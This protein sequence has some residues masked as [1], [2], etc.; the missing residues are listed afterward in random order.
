MKHV[1]LALLVAISL[2]A[3]EF[4]QSKPFAEWTDKDVQRILAASPWVRQVTVSHGGS[5]ESSHGNDRRGSTFD[6]N[7]GWMS[8]PS[9][10]ERA[11][12]ASGK[13]RGEQTGDEDRSHGASQA[14]LTIQWRSALPIKQV[15]KRL[16]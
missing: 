8:V 13:Q 2:P 9:G 4:W 14:K 15:A 3:A 10:S 7:P 6:D 12:V 16:V 1:L 11:D 5:S